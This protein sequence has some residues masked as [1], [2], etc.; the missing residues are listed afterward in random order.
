MVIVSGQGELSRMLQRVSLLQTFEHSYK[1]IKELVEGWE[2]STGIIR[3]A[4]PLDADLPDTDQTKDAA[5]D[6][7]HS[8][9]G[10]KA[11]KGGR[12]TVGVWQEGQER[13]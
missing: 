2:R 10:R 5:T 11:K 8:A 3:P 9:S 1:D 12:H 7:G 13:R 6:K 4:S